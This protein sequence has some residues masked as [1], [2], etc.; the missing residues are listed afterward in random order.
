[1]TGDAHLLVRPCRADD[2]PAVAAIYAH[3]VL[4]GLASFEEVPPGEAELAR[5]R[6][7]V[8]GHGLPWLVAELGGSVAGYAYAAPYRARPAYRFTVEDS[9]YVAPGLGGRGV[10]RALLGRLVGLCEAA[11]RRQMVAVIGD[12]A[13]LGSV[14]LHERLGFRRVGVLEAVGCKHGRWV[15]SVLMQRAL[16]AEGRTLP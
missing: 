7:E 1:L 13:N 10:G 12:S 2:L 15:D 3:H 11:G 8:L 9:V 6:E 5:R 4:H 14:R 16:G